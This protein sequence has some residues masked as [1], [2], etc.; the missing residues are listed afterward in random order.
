MPRR[1]S[2]RRSSPDLNL[3]E[4]QRGQTRRIHNTRGSQSGQVIVS[5]LIDE[6][7]SIKG[8]PP[9][10][11][12]GAG[13]PH[14]HGVLARPENHRVEERHRNLFHE[15]PVVDAGLPDRIQATW[16][17]AS[18]VQENGILL[19]CCALFDVSDT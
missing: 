15:Y 8:W 9:R 18:L 7:L 2:I 16:Q 11:C 4:L 1:P 12:S 6:L 10:T 14:P 17:V 19:H 13:T 3:T 5:T